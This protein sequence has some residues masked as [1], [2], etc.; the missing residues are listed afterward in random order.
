MQVCDENHIDLYNGLILR[1]SSAGPH[2]KSV[3]VADQTAVSARTGYE[4]SGTATPCALARG[5]P[6]PALGGRRPETR[7]MQREPGSPAGFARYTAFIQMPLRQE[8]G[9]SIP[10][11]DIGVFTVTWFW[12]EL[13]ASTN[14]FRAF[15]HGRPPTTS[16][17][18]GTPGRNEPRTSL[19]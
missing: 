17:I 13:P 3:A 12:P 9:R 2:L 16:Q 19:A 15:A 11:S 4:P 6:A 8:H 14:V 5:A 10:F 1:V 7:Y 18:L